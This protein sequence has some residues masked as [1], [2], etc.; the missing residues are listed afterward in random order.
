MDWRQ[1]EPAFSFDAQLT[2]FDLELKELLG[3]NT[4]EYF[5]AA[6]VLGKLAL[7]AYAKTEAANAKTEAANVKEYEARIKVVVLTRDLLDA[8]TE[9]LRLKGML[10]VD[11]RGMLE[12]VERLISPGMIRNPKVKRTAVARGFALAPAHGARRRSHRL[13]SHAAGQRRRGSSHIHHQENLQKGQQQDPLTH[14]LQH[15]RHRRSPPRLSW[16]QRV[17]CHSGSGQVL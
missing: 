9:T 11:V 10:D 6:S 14:R 17:G 15:H 12:E 16:G 13:L 5:K 3:T 7:H 4:V 1:I 2:H 8:N